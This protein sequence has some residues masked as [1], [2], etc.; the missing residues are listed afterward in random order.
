M[1]V[2]QPIFLWGL[3]AAAIPVIVH[4]IFRW[5]TRKVD[6]GTLRFL[7]EIIR[8]NARRKRLKRW[9]L[10]A[11]R[12]GAV[13][14]IAVLFARPYLPAMHA[15]D[16]QRLVVVLVDQSA[17][18]S[19]ERD[20]ERLVDRAVNRAKQILRETGE[21][22]D[23]ELAFFDDAVHP[24]S[25]A[26][27]QDNGIDEIRA[28]DRLYGSTS[29][30]AALAWARDL[31]IKSTHAVREVHLLTD[32]QRSGLDWTAAD[33]FPEGVDV[34]VEDLGRSNVNNVAVV[35]VQISRTLVRPGE[36]ALVQ[37]TLFNFGPFSLDDAPVAL[38]F[39]SG[40]Q[41][42]RLRQLVGLPSQQAVDVEF[43]APPLAAGLWK[44][45]VSIEVDDDLS[46]DNRRYAAVLAA[47]Q[48]RTLIIDGSARADDEGEDVAS[49]GPPQTFFLEAALRLSEPG[50]TYA[51]SPFIPTTTSLSED[52]FPAL[53]DVDLVVLA[54]MPT[55]ASAE[56][57]RL[58]E[59]VKNGGGL[60]LLAGEN[61]TPDR[62]KPLI[63][64]GV[65]PGEP[66]EVVRAL[67][68]P[69]RLRT[70]DASHPLLE[71]FADPQ[72][73]DLKR[74]AFMAYVPIE[75]GHDATILA[76][77]E[78]DRPLLV[79]KPIDRG[80]VLWFGGSLN[81]NWG[82]WTRSR[83]F[84]PLVHQMLGDLAGLTRAFPNHR[85]W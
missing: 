68:L 42:H 79:Q 69:F 36:S 46:F 3:A 1:N 50:E 70:W 67:D 57:K 7:A 74:L 38:T 83:L 45:V 55:L 81:R 6:L 35:D 2:V 19:L 71:P 75:P 72:Y 56:A 60:L 59:F 43:E 63:D 26:P 52:G 33:S 11:L 73:G 8:E 61:T 77:F 27:D 82:D 16:R 76:A 41:T 10:L 12:V 47:P 23:W 14:L 9:L 25:E 48:K 39:E 4:L 20:G 18:M 84:L 34:R 44:A 53:A 32:L 49:A 21:A 80:R 58:A 28:P 64:A 85:R 5:Q 62:L 66:G 17:G 54:D 29:Y 30:G 78:K 37:T 24:L 40:R 15:S 51:G 31:C 22:A 13:A 65:L